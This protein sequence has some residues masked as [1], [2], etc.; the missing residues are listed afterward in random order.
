M[1]PTK[2]IFTIK[3]PIKD[4]DKT[5]EMLLKAGVKKVE[6]ECGFYENQKTWIFTHGG[7][8][9][10]WVRNKNTKE[11]VAGILTEKM[12]NTNVHLTDAT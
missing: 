2:V 7:S 8:E 10:K 1:K 3:V 4:F 6:Y 9:E 12:A 11:D 5:R